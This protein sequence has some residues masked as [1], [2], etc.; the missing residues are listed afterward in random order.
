MT[1]QAI[2]WNLRAELKEIERVVKQNGCAIHL[3][4]NA[5]ANSEAGTKIHECLTSSKWNYECTKY[6]DSTG[7]KLKYNKTIPLCKGSGR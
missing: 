2:G 4:K 1:S 7:W 6:K 5:D 3:F